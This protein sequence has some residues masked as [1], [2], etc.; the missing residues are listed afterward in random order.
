MIITIAIIVLI[1]IFY[2][3]K[4][5]NMIKLNMIGILSVNR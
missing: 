5:H 3:E 2:I 1:I 4:K